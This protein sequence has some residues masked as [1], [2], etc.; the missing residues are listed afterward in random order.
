MKCREIENFGSGL[1]KN[2]I[3]C[4]RDRE[5]K[6]IIAQGYRKIGYTA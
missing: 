4:D 3:Y 6:E 1:L 2:R 5:Q